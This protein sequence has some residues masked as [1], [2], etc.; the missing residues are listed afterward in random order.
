MLF[1]DGL[2]L[3]IAFWT[4]SQ[5]S[6]EFTIPADKC[7]F[8][9]IHTNG[10]TQQNRSTSGLTLILS[11]FPLYIII[12]GPNHVLETAP[13]ANFFKTTIIPIHGKTLYVRVHY[14]YRKL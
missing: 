2:N 12:K 14:I 8:D 4:A 3:R 9:I 10:D 11:D 1:S 6:H 7:D 13:E 5:E